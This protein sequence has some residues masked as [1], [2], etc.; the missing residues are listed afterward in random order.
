MWL[1]PPADVRSSAFSN[2]ILSPLTFSSPCPYKIECDDSGETISQ[3]CHRKNTRPACRFLRCAR[4]RFLYE[5]SPHEQSSVYRTIGPSIWNYLITNK[6][7]PVGSTSAVGGCRPRRS[8]KPV[9][10]RANTGIGNP[11]KCIHWQNAL[12]QIVKKRVNI[13]CT[14]H[15]EHVL[16]TSTLCL[17][18]FN[19]NR[20]DHLA[21]QDW[22]KKA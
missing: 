18:Y 7:P 15:V 4:D 17:L 22:R 5:R 21:N 1:R 16:L 10:L 12:S 13:M 19:Y 3:Y 9:I 8:T 2:F 14:L 11:E 20:I 6:R